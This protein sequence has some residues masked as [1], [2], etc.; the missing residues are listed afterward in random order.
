MHTTYNGMPATE[1]HGVT[2]HK[3]HYSSPNGN[4]VEIAKLPGGGVAMRNSRDP[5]GP[6]LIY[7]PAEFIAF[8]DGARDGDFDTLI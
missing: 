1:L 5:N 4:C 8:L 6:A 3:S 7:T 2:W